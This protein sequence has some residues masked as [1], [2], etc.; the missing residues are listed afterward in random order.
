MVGDTSIKKIDLHDEMT[1]APQKSNL[2]RRL[3]HVILSEFYDDN[4]TSRFYDNSGINEK[5]TFFGLL[6]EDKYFPYPPR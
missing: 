6:F 4:I 3:K 2:G 1:K 5:N